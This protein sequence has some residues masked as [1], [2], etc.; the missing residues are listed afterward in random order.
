MK[1]IYWVITLAD[2]QGRERLVAR[3]RSMKSLDAVLESGLAVF[4]DEK[5]ALEPFVRFDADFDPV[6]PIHPFRVSCD[7]AQQIHLL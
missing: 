3:Y 1:W 4:N 2:E 5:E 6:I 7:G